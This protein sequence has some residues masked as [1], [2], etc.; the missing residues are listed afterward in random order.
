VQVPNKTGYQTYNRNKY[1]TASPHRL[2]LMLYEGALRYGAQAVRA[3]EE[4]DISLTN[5]SLQKV[6][7]IL[8]ELLSSLDLKQGGEIAKNLQQLY[9]YMIEQCIQAN[10]HKDKAKIN[11]VLGYLQTIKSAW[12][13]IGKEVAI[14]RA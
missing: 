12:E 1:E 5:K 6:Q 2:I 4:H 11:E 8:Y 14:G 13:Q 9:L 3:I 7:D 10:L